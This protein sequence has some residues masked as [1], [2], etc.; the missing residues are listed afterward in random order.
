MRPSPEVTREDV[1]ARRGRAVYQTVGLLLAPAL[2]IVMMALPE[3]EGLTPA[4]WR[5]AALGIWMG[6]WWATEAVPVAVT[7][8][9]PIALF[10]LLGVADIRA[11]TAPFANPTIYLFLGGFMVALAM[12]RWNLHRRIALAVT[13][14]FGGSG[15]SIVGGF[16]LASALVSM[17]VTNTSTTMMLLPI[18]ASVVAVVKQNLESSEASDRFAKAMLLGIAYAA[19][20][21]GMATLVGTPP[22]ALLAAFMFENYGQEVGFAQWM[23]VGVP[24]SVCLLPICWWLL[25]HRV[26]PVRFTTRGAAHDH[27]LELRAG[28]GSMSRAERRVA[29]VAV[30]LGVAWVTRPLLARL[31]GLAGLSDTGVAMLA[32]LSLFR[33]P[34]GEEG[35][36]RLLAW[37]DTRALPWGVLVLFGGGLALAGA[38]SSTGLAAWMGQRLLAMGLTEL[39]VLVVTIATLIIFLTELTSNLATTATFLPVVAAVAASAGFAPIALTAPVAL[40]ASCAFMLPVATPPNAVVFSSGMLTVPDMV[41]AGFWMNLVGILLVS[42][43]ALLLAPLVLG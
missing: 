34:S 32:A 16:M 33:V 13:A 15:S 17:W 11:V 30:C 24:L 9:M 43:A 21:G 20:I 10:P 37:D 12:Q 36:S 4:G 23:L 18:A 26:Y 31:P 3:P 41:R 40:A 8:L 39:A 7:A 1:R 35:S 25:T 2:A 22:N 14:R 19:T 5:A 6:I 29:L 38:V 42:A 28:L 27:L